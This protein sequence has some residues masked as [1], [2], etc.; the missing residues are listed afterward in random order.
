MKT[1]PAGAERR[2]AVRIRGIAYTY[3][4]ESRSVRELAACGS[5]ESESSVLEGFGFDR[6]H[7]AVEE[8][9]YAL[10]HEAASRLLDEQR[11]VPESVGLLVC[12]GTPSAMAFSAAT[13]ADAGAASLC[14]VDRFRYPATRL[15]HELGLECAAVL[16]LDQLACTTLFGAVRVAHAMMESEGIERALCVASE[17][18]PAHAGREA[19]YNCTS[20]AACALLLERTDE[21]EAR[22]RIVGAATITK[23]YYWDAAA[24]R[25]EVVA[26]YFPTA[27]HAIWRTLDSAG[28]RAD[29]VDWVIPHNVSARSWEVLLRLAHLQSAKLWSRNIA[30]RGHAL[31]GDNFINL[32]DAIDAGDLRPGQRALLFS[33]G[34][35]AH[36]T[37][38][39]V[40]A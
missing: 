22:N 10:A 4:T 31:A 9:P 28:W 11:V 29:D 37:A 15:Q 30:R 3:A 26:S 13:D 40:E 8:S 7:V 19:L 16:A 1:E 35:G 5:L 17:F 21:S 2:H 34:Y 39:A 38:L 18:Y 20:D 12:G 36:W 33:Y 6:V 25:E 23:G 14:T 24:M 27:V 32:R